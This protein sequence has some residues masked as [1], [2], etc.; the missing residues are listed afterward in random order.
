MG[1]VQL[2]MKSKF[3]QVRQKTLDIQR[4]DADI[5]PGNHYEKHYHMQAA[6]EFD[7]ELSLSLRILRETCQA[8]LCDALTQ[9]DVNSHA[10]FEGHVV[11]DDASFL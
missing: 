3:S 1:S 7:W 8:V 4:I 10:D 5:I 2:K 11:V 6:Y 9:N